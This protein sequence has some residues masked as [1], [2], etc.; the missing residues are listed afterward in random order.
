MWARR[1]HQTIPRLIRS[2]AARGD[3]GRRA[4][5]TGV[6]DPRAGQPAAPSDLVDVASLVTAY[7]TLVPDPA[8]PAQRVAFGTSGHRGSSFDTAFNEAHILA[9]TPPTCDDRAAQGTEGPLFLGRDPHALSEPAW[10]SALEV[11]AAN[12]VT[13]LVDAAGRYT[14]TPPVSHALPTATRGRTAGPPR[15]RR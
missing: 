2:R 9:T 8:E 4:R 10:A 5:I 7:Y 12:D 14:P 15:A 3:V 11:L 1:I 13:V 6:T